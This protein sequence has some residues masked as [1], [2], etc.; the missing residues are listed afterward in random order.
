MTHSRTSLGIDISQ[1]RISFALLKQS[2]GRITL[3]KAAAVPTPEGAMTDG[4]ITAPALLAKAVKRLLSKNG[5]QKHSATFSLAVKPSLLR[6]IDLPDEMPSN[7]SQFVQSEIKHNA[8]FAGKETA[9]DYCGIPYTTGSRDRIFVC[10]AEKDGVSTLLK[11]VSLAKIGADNIDPA[12]T[13]SLRSIYDKRIRKKYDSNVLIAMVEKSGV[14]ICVFRKESLD[15]IRSIDFDSDTMEAQDCIEHCKSE[16]DAVIQF[17]DIEVEDTE[18]DWEIS[19][20]LRDMDIDDDPI[21]QQLQSRFGE[22]ARVCCDS[23]VYSDTILKPNE[24]VS[25]ASLT[26]VGLALAPFKTAGPNLN[27]DMIPSEARDAKAVKKLLLV[28]AIASIAVLFGI[29]TISVAVTRR[30]GET[31]KIVEKQKQAHIVTDYKKLIAEQSLLDIQIDELSKLKESMDLILADDKGLR[32]WPAILDDIRKRVPSKLYIANIQDSNGKEITIEGKAISVIA[33]HKFAEMLGMSRYFQKA[34]ITEV[35]RSNRD[36][37]LV[38][39]SI[40]CIV[41]DNG[42]LQANAN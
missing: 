42:R 1:S 34:S 3:L 28:T 29:F 23:T 25:S 21:R 12:M 40:K 33:T 39:Y 18:D 13:A 35:G 31:E 41:A 5:I 9:S 17:Y 36:P 11:T 4:R 26:A 19:V 7:I 27:I 38:E 10:A 32:S 22:K 2:Q 16:I 8:I 14:T 37:E 20:L 15:F 6:L 24:K 30:F